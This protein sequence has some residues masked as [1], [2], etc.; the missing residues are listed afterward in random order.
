MILGLLKLWMYSKAPSVCPPPPSRLQF[1]Q[2]QVAVLKSLIF[3][4]G[5]CLRSST[6]PS[7]PV[8]TERTAAGG[9][10]IYII[11]MSMILYKCRKAMS[12]Q[13]LPFREKSCVVR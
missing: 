13:A 5:V 11:I 1:F 6:S 4:I 9:K 3:L 7:W 12:W 10:S 2:S 8:P